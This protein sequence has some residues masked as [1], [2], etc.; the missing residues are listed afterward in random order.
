MTDP[1]SFVGAKAVSHCAKTRGCGVC[2]RVRG[3]DAWVAPSRSMICYRFN[4]QTGRCYADTRSR[5]TASRSRRAST[6][7]VST[8]N[9]MAQGMPSARRAVVA[10]LSSGFG[11]AAA[12]EAR[13]RGTWAS[14]SIM[15]DAPTAT[16]TTAALAFLP[17]KAVYL[18]E[19]MA[20]SKAHADDVHFHGHRLGGRLKS[21]RGK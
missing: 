11:E 5:D 14:W 10:V 7:V 21:G 4:C 19:M 17:T 20:K 1:P 16:L 18:S 2:R 12:T 8:R 13:L 15:F 3:D 9:Q 6:R